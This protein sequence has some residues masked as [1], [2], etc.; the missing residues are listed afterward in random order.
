M[1]NCYSKG[2][3]SGDNAGGI[4]GSYAGYNSGNVIVEKS[5]SLGAISG[6]F[7]G[8]I[9]GSYTGYDSGT[10]TVTNCYSFGETSTDG[11][12]IFGSKATDYNDVKDSY[13]YVAKGNWSDQAADASLNSATVQ[14]LSSLEEEISGNTIYVDFD[15]LTNVPY[16][17]SWQK[18]YD[19]SIKPVLNVGQSLFS[20]P[21]ALLMGGNICKL[22]EDITITNNFYFMFDGPNVIF[23]G[24]GHTVTIIDV[25]DFNGLF[26]NGDT[27]SR[28]NITIKNLGVIGT[29][30]TLANEAGWICQR[31]FGRGAS[32][33]KIENCYS[34]GVINHQASGGICGQNAGNNGDLTITNCYSSGNISYSHGGGICGQY[35]GNNG[36]TVTITNCYSSGN[37]SSSH[38][39]G[40]C[41]SYAGNSSGTVTITNCY[42]SG[43]ISSSHIGGICGFGAGNTNGTVTI[44]NCYSSG[45]VS[46]DSS[47]GICG[48]YAGHTNG[49]VTITKCYSEGAILG[50]RAGGICGLNAGHTTGTVTITKSYSSGNVSGHSSGGICGQNAGNNKGTVTITKCYSSGNIS[51]PTTGGICGYSAG[52]SSGTVTVSNCYSS[53][54]ISGGWAGGI[55]GQYAGNN[56]GT[57]IATNCFSAGQTSD[58]GQGIFGSVIGTTTKQ[59]NCYAVGTGTW[60]DDAADASLNSLTVQHID[61]VTNSI[62][63][64]DD[65]IYVDYTQATKRQSYVL[66]WQNYTIIF[67]TSFTQEMID[68]YSNS[69]GYYSIEQGDVILLNTNIVITKPFYFTFEGPDIMF[70]GQGHTIDISGVTDFGGLFRNGTTGENGKNDITIKNLGVTSSGTTTLETNAGWICQSYFGRDASSNKIENCYSNGQIPENGGGICGSYAG[71]SSGNVIVENSYSLGDISGNKAGGICGLDAGSNS[72]TV[73]VTNCYSDGSVS[74]INRGIFGS[75]ASDKKEVSQTNCYIANDNWSDTTA[76]A[77]LNSVTVQHLSSYDEAIGSDTIYVDYERASNSQPYALSWQTYTKVIDNIAIN[78][79][80]ID[81]HLYRG[82]VPLISGDTLVSDITITSDFYFTFVGSG[83]TFDGSGHTIDI[84]GVMSGFGGLFQNGTD[85]TTGKNNITIKKLGITSSG[86]TILASNGGWI[87]RAY[88]GTG[89]SNNNIENCYSNGQI[90]E[91]GGGICGSYAGSNNGKLSVTNSY[92]LGDI[93]GD[94]AG[95]ICGL[96]AGSN[97]GTVTVTNCYSDGSVSHIDRGIFGSTASDKKEVSQTNCYTAND[98]WSDTTADASLNSVTVQHL[99]SYDE[100]IGSDTIYVDYERASN[101][102]PYALSWQTYTKVIDNIAINQEWIDNH[103]YRGTVPLISGDTLVSDI[104]ITSDF[105]FTFDGP[106]VTFDGSGH[107]IDIS[108]VP[109]FNGLFR[110]GTT[111]ENGKNDITIKNLGVTSSGTTTL[112]TT[113][114]WICQSYFGR[115]ASNNKIENCYS[116]GQIPENGGGICGSHTGDSSGNVIVSNCYSLG[117]ISGNK[118]GGICGLDAGS[119]SGTVTVTN[120]YSDGSVSDINRGIFGSTASDKKEVSQT[121]CYTANDNWSDTT[122]DASLNS[123]TVQH[124]SSYDEAIGSDT[125]Y[126]DYE[127]A[128]NSQPYALS[129]Q[130]YTKVIDNIAINQEWI[131]N[132]LYRGTVPLISGDT[133]VSDITITSD[134][135]FTFVGPGVTFDG[136]GHTID[137]SGVMSGFGGLFRNGTTG[138]NGKNDITIKNLGVTSS[139]TTTLKTTAGWV[140]QSY[141]GRDASNNKIENCYSNGQIPENGGGI[142]GSHTGDSSGNVI[143]SNCYSL[144]DISGNKAGGICGLD[145]GSNSG[146]VTVTNCYSDGSVSHIDRGIFGSTASD[147]KEVSQTNCYIANDNWSDTTA[148]ASLNSVT[149]QHLSSYDEAIGSGTVYV[150]YERASNSQPYALSWQTYTKVIDN[151]AINQEWIDNH[152]YR[153]TVPLISGDTLVSDITITSDFYFT[154]DGPGVTFDGSGH[155]IDISGVMSGFGGLF[156]NGTTGENGKN[157]IT[158]KNLGVTSS[159]TTTLKTTAGWVCQSY[160][161]TGASNNNIENCYSNGQIPENGGGICGSHTGDSSGNVIVENSYSLG[162]ISENKAGGICGLD[163]GSNSGTVTVTNCYSDGSV[164]DINRG[165]FGSTA[166]DKKEVSQTN[167]YIANDNWSDTTA[168]ASL[169]SV[170]VQHLSS[171]DEAI[172]SDTIYVDYNYNFSNV[173]YA[174]FWQTNYEKV[175]LTDI[176]IN[177]DWIDSSYNYNINIEED[178][179]RVYNLIS[180]ITYKLVESISFN[181]PVYFIFNGPGMILDG[182]PI[183]FDGSGHTIDISGVTGFNGLFQNGTTGENGKNDITIKNLGVTSSVSTTLASNAGWICQSYFGRDA[184]SNN[185]ENCYSNGQIPENGGGICGSHT[186]DSSGNV[187][188]SNCYSLGDISGNKAGGICGLDAGSNSGTVT[189]TNCYSDGSVSDIN[190]GIFGSTASDKKEVSQ[191]NCYIANGDWSDTAADASLNSVRIQYLSSHQEEIS[192]NTIY[193]D[194]NYNF[195]NVSYAL[196]WQTNYEKVILTDIEINQDWIDSSYNYNIEEDNTRV[197]NLISKITYKL[198]ESISFNDP[199]YFIFNGPGMILD[200]APIIFDGSGHTIDISGVTGFNGLF[201]NGTTTESGK[202][203]ITIKNLGVTS[204]GSTTLASN[205][206]WICQSYFG[207]DASS[208]NIENCYSN[209][210]ITSPHSGGICGSYAGSNNGSLNV[211]NCYFF[212]AITGQ[213]SGGI[214]GSYVG[215]SNGTVTVS[216]CYNVGPVIIGL[217]SGGILGQSAGSNYGRVTLIN[218]YSSCKIFGSGSGGICGRYTGD[219]NGIIIINN[220]YSLGEISGNKAGGICGSNTGF[221]SG[222]VT[223]TNCYSAGSVSDINRGIFGSTASDKEEVSQ[224]NCYTAN[225]DWSDTAA[226]TSLDSATIQHLSSLEEAIDSGTVYVDYERASNSQPYALSWQNNDTIDNIAINQEWIDNHLYRGTVPLISGDTLVSDITIT[227]DFYF[228]FDGPGV[229]FDGSG[230][231]IDISGVPDFNGLFRNGTDSEP[232]KNDIT[233]KNLGVTSSGT[234]TLET[235][236]GW[237]CQSYFGRDASSNKIEN[238]YSNGQIP[239]NGGGICGSHTGDSSGNVIVSNCYSLGDI[240]GDQ[241]GGI[242]GLDAG[243]NS[244]TVTVTNCYSDGSVSDINR[245]IFGSTASDKKEVSQTNC[246]IANDNWSDTTADAS[247]NSVTVQHLSSYDEAIGSDTIYL[248]YERASNS[249]PY[250]LS[251][252]TYT[253]VIDNIAINQEWIDNHLYR[254]TV[255]L[256]SGDTLVSDITITSDFYFTFVGSGVTFDGQGNT[257]D[258]SGVMSGFGGLFQNGTDGTT[259]KNNITIK[260]LGITSSGTTILASN[261]GW[262]GRAYFGTGASNNNIENCYSNGQIP[263]NGGGI[264]GSYA[265]SNN[266]KLSV[267]NS[268]S[269]GDISGDQAGGICGQYAG[270]NSGTVTVTNC[271][272]DGSVSDINRGIF[273]SNKSNES[274]GATSSN[275]YVTEGNWQDISAN[276][277]LTNVQQLTKSMTVVRSSTIYIDYTNYLNSNTTPYVLFWQDYIPSLDQ[278][279]TFNIE[280]SV[281][282]GINIIFTS[283]SGQLNGLNLIE[284]YQLN[285]GTIHRYDVTNNQYEPNVVWYSS[286]SVNNMSVN[287]VNAANGGTISYFGDGDMLEY[288]TT[289]VIPGWNII[290]WNSVD[291]EKTGYIIDFSNIIMENTIHFYDTVRNKYQIES[292][293]TTSII[294]NIGYWVKCSDHGTIIV[295]RN[296]VTIDKNDNITM[297]KLNS[298]SI[299]IENPYNNTVES[300]LSTNTSST[301]TIDN[302]TSINQPVLKIDISKYELNNKPSFINRNDIITNAN[303]HFM[304][305]EWYYNKEL[306]TIMYGD[307]RNWDVSQVTSFNKLFYFVPNFNEDI[308]NWNTSN[309]NDMSYMFYNS[310]QFNHDITKWNIEKVTNF[311]GMFKGINQEF[312]NRYDINKNIDEFGHPNINFFN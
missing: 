161:G 279:P 186:G 204:S 291:V 139:G 117:D 180:K 205:A 281:Y 240:S 126:V 302:T 88:F 184:S 63:L 243:S 86:T 164:S 165:I 199:V 154:F 298:D 52:N 283:S 35:A 48:G 69:Q 138:E 153:G 274:D 101:S 173:S 191:T 264:C 97:S 147:K 85:G 310:T 15:Y 64:N 116:N 24:Q 98:N 93:S 179:T 229:T 257:I 84:S 271:Y 83:V 237:I 122:A 294:P 255:P 128:S 174:L 256:I 14:H 235:N 121:N 87:G 144:G 222:K 295:A 50:G 47:G 192:G 9:C 200:G 94:Q 89:A 7:S 217:Y 81:N 223:V 80:W 77:S 65:T 136:S 163:A 202:N 190:R 187:I 102:Q 41:G 224:T 22:T 155:T 8:G 12:G 273:G 239:K 178:N 79:E 99:S 245:G 3:I 66:S 29:N 272:S 54:N 216:K 182:A 17:L 221:G 92:S 188:V 61:P 6:H 262:I 96:D 209:G 234:T 299:K 107:T 45:N 228:T 304:L 176:E 130:T 127:R 249:Q 183:I 70:D 62:S 34:E 276:L 23:D 32:N 21:Y 233:I 300:E 206:G 227:S 46:G 169:N 57:V 49:T 106:G 252:Q 100:A 118:A 301:Q 141:F 261:G 258:I 28:G 275:C 18:N 31:Y 308:S 19:I 71:D 55:C 39:G 251:W 110:N 58:S 51:G 212:G 16:A 282:T 43:L 311:T 95:G 33:N 248:D 129:W 198:V 215:D 148:D 103:L 220:C 13:C 232:G 108:G 59:T 157:D 68:T 42:S 125:I 133:L 269:L 112:E 265:G 213:Y 74:D 1:T 230:H 254:G 73:T 288:Y 270:S 104:T 305:L 309:V 72:G 36:G 53:G 242:C 75:T 296:G 114:G 278:Y 10:V 60:S 290:G 218:S 78:Q 219:T 307:I 214:C 203:D 82:T 5:Y 37:I 189:V 289:T 247:L 185:I 197:Y 105:Y 113:A 267:T 26:Y 4:C 137:I 236:A 111:G 131:D 146:T 167:C 132:H 175:I 20:G 166:S 109:D 210:T 263:E 277:I 297:V 231:T 312:I 27:L 119:N 208:N 226:D 280:I 162:D 181:E 171:Y 2:A 225:G 143:V 30:S 285:T 158:I 241:A 91:N 120:C 196:F 38:G 124:L 142:C 150:D 160:F 250:A 246:Y 172:G 67:N 287:F 238:C 268:Y 140:C 123:V 293:Y 168:D 115:D 193:V 152:L 76:D 56:N 201:Q 135:Y 253:K 170:T 11:E 90:P 195:S 145:A 244:G 156:R 40:I 207:R 292:K 194:Y 306:A 259:G 260:K 159:G 266:G 25:N 303:L 44:T 151:I 211:I 134:F 286:G 149:V 284:G 177:Q